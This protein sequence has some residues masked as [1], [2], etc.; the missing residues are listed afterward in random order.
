MKRGWLGLGILVVFLL[1]GIMIS[2]VMCSAH[3][4][5]QDLLQQAASA[6]L[7]GDFAQAVELGMEAK[8]RWETKW[9]GTAIVADHTPMDEIDAL[10]AEMEIYAKTQEEPHFAACCQELAKRLL[11]M[12]EA[13]RFSWW[14]VL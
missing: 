11:A 2:L 10:F 6:T 3:L 7:A 4:P 1:L 13:H 12:A 8:N 9:N 5:T 14:N